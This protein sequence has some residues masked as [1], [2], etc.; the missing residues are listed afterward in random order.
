MGVD[1]GSA[2]LL[3]TVTQIGYAVGIFFVVPLGDVIERRRLIPFFLAS[4]AISLVAAAIVPT[5]S[6]LLVGFAL[7]GA[8][9]VAGQM[10]SPLAGD[11]ADPASRG[12]VVSTISSG[13]LIGLLFS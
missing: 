3:V 8:T 12:R 4:S 7:V 1:P 10:L 13:I 9:S 5:Y 11:L 6:L 2:G